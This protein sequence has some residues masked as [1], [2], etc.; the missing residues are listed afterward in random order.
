MQTISHVSLWSVVFWCQRFWWNSGVI[1][2][3]GSQYTWGRKDL[4]L[5]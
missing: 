3:E 5:V 1:S 4:W 2:N